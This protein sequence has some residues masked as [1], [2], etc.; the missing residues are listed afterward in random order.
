MKE[1]ATIN[2]THIR[3]IEISTDFGGDR[4]GGMDRGA[5]TS[6]TKELCN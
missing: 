4:Y 2:E 5:P 1:S 3:N 6:H